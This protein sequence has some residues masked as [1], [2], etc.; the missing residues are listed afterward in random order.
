MIDVL[1]RLPNHLNWWHFITWNVHDTHPQQRW[2]L[3]FLLNIIQT[4][5]RIYEELIRHGWRVERPQTC[6]SPTRERTILARRAQRRGS[7]KH[8][9]YQGYLP[10]PPRTQN[11]TQQESTLRVQLPIE[12]RP[13]RLQSNLF[14]SLHSQ[15]SSLNRRLGFDYNMVDIH[16]HRHSLSH[17]TTSN[18]NAICPSWDLT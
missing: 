12:Q 2:A 15:G 6:W 11:R 1:A 4:T 10:R 13:H 14:H 9:L 7:F 5:H 3:W 17:S 18:L 8:V 16:I